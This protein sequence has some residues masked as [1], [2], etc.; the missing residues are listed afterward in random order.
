MLFWVLEDFFWFIINPHYGW[1]R[2]RQQEIAWHP[3]WFWILPADHWVM[4][5][6]GFVLLSWAHY[7][8]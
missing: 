2:Y 5:L 1:K 8:M 4:I 3:K 7:K 6:L